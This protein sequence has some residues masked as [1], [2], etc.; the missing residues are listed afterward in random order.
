MDFGFLFLKDMCTN[1]AMRKKWPFMYGFVMFWEKNLQW[2]TTKGEEMSLY[3]VNALKYLYGSTLY[4]KNCFQVELLN[5]ALKSTASC[6]DGVLTWE[7]YIIKF[8]TSQITRSFLI[9]Y[10]I[11]KHLPLYRSGKI[12]KIWQPVDIG[13]CW[14]QPGKCFPN[15]WHMVLGSNPYL[16][17]V[18][19]GRL[20]F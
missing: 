8:Y 18:V 13:K 9:L 15:K 11:K 20:A 10:G 6:G 16:M 19:A 1:D 3:V 2:E 14:G 7:W 4:F 5:L 12:N 17:V